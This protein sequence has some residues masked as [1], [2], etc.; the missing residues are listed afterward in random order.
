M[1]G[2][3][4]PVAI[5]MLFSIVTFSVILIFWDENKPAESSSLIDV[6]LYKE[7]IQE[8]KQKEV[9]TVGIM[10]SMWSAVLHIFIF[11]WNPILKSVTNYSFN[12]GMVFLSYVLMIISGTKLYEIFI[13]H[14]KFNEFI[15]LA[16]CLLIEMFSFLI[17]FNY[18]NFAVRYIM[19]TLINGTCGFYQPINSV[20][21]SKILKEKYRAFLMNIFR[22]PLNLYVIFVLSFIKQLE[23]NNVSH[24]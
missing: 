3:F 1:F 8:L 13:I 7:A 20:I 11:A 10:E 16:S 19:C 18:E 9:Y 12:P 6:Q 21:K 22:I 17:I 23:Y 24:Q 14:K 4:G 2:I 5:S 15:C